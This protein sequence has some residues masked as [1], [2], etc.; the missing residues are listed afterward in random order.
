LVDERGQRLPLVGDRL[1]AGRSAQCEIRL[2][3][4]LASRSHFQL[5]RT[6][7]GWQ[8]EDLRSTNGTLLNGRRLPPGAPVPV[9]LSDRI[10]VGHTTFVMQ[11]SAVQP[12]PGSRT[13]PGRV[14][15]SANQRMGESANQRMAVPPR[16]GPRTGP[17]QP[18]IVNRLSSI[19]AWQWILSALIVAAAALL[20]YG[21]FQPWVRVQVQL[22]FGGVAGG[23][24]LTKG[25][26]LLDGVLQDFL[27][28]PP[29]VTA[30]TV[31]IS[32]IDSYGWFTLVAGCVAALVAALDLALRLKRSA[33]PGI[34]YL[35]AALLPGVVLAGD[36]QRFMRLG[37]V[38]VLF[39]VNLLDVFQGA[40]KIM[41]PKVTPLTGL[42]MTAIGLAL[43][44]GVGVLR[45]I[46][47]ALTRKSRPTSPVP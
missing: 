40:S 13:G 24:L 28:K 2:S 30:N 15:E 35:L 44:I 45:S 23:E 38:P 32:G 21:A 5:Q 1:V 19:P 6:P 18:S 47:P 34:V 8:I 16:P 10:T 42:Y 39:G 4:E 33:L 14:G 9:A 43:L 36:V 25:L 46:L 12:R 37:S 17:G 7:A 27:K 41:E 31:E 26:T 29:M 3:D 20:V 22:T 11:R